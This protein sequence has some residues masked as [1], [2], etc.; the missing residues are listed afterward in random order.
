MER[1]GECTCIHDIATRHHVTDYA[2]VIVT[3]ITEALGLG[4]EEMLAFGIEQIVLRLVHVLAS[5]RHLQ[6]E[7][8]D[9]RVY[10]EVRTI[11]TKY[12]RL[13]PALLTTIITEYRAKENK[14]ARH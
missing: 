9:R 8:D 10:E 14:D 2:D 5:M 11:L 7:I 13:S 4:C 1:E 3:E 6:R 12:E